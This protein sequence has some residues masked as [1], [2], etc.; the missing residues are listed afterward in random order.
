MVLESKWDLVFAVKTDIINRHIISNGI[1]LIKEFSYKHE[2]GTLS[3][4]IPTFQIGWAGNEQY[5]ELNITLRNVC[6][7][8]SGISENTTRFKV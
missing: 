3:G 4:S 2:A 7:S 1:P 8:Y 6:I 5:M